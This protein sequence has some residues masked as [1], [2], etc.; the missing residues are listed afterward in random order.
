MSFLI[1]KG[2]QGSGLGIVQN[3]IARITHGMIG[4]DLQAQGKINNKFVNDLLSLKDEEIIEALKSSSV[5]TNF[6]KFAPVEE[7]IIDKQGSEIIS[8]VEKAKKMIANKE[9]VAMA[10]LLLLDIWNNRLNTNNK[11]LSDFELK[12]LAGQVLNY[13]KDM[14]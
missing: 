1:T 9:T 5:S 3:V 14:A 4:L 6:S 13:L 12:R 7:K 10:S 2:M 11:L 8:T